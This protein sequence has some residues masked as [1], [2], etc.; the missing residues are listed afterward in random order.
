[1][2]RS[3]FSKERTKSQSPRIGA[4]IRIHH[5]SG[6]TKK[7][8]VSIPSNRG[9]HSNLWSLPPFFD[10][11]SPGLNPLESGQ[12]FECKAPP[13]NHLTTT[14]SQSPRIGAVIRI[15]GW[16]PRTGGPHQG[17]NP[18]ESGQSFEYYNRD[19][20]VALGFDMSQSPR[21]GAVI[22][23]YTAMHQ[24][25]GGSMSQSPRIGAVIRMQSSLRSQFLFPVCLNPLESGQSFEYRPSTK[26]RSSKTSVSIPSNRGSH[27]NQ[28]IRSVSFLTF[29]WKVSIPSNRGSHSN[30]KYFQV[31]GIAVFRVSIPSNRGSHSNKSLDTTEYVYSMSQSPRI[32]AV[33]R[34]K[35]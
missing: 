10:R 7:D 12:S 25:Y 14:W 35:K 2:F 20:A 15:K 6:E 11:N 19:E 18:L 21:I 9:S 5:I 16:G 31:K 26:C 3:Y 33:I 32:G 28:R 1:M 27:S 4:V 22:R 24:A 30:W 8:T 29:G 23:M 17:L 13:N 34:I